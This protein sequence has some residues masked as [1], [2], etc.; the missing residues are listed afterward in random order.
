MSYE[1]DIYG[2]VIGTGGDDTSLQNEKMAGYPG[3]NMFD[4]QRDAAVL[5]QGE[6]EGKT[7]VNLGGTPV[8]N[9]APTGSQIANYVQG[10][11]GMP[12][13][14]SSRPNV[15][16]TRS[17][18]DA[19]AAAA[20]ERAAGHKVWG[21]QGTGM[22][23]E[24]WQRR[25]PITST[26][27]L[28]AAMGYTSPEEE[29]RLRKASVTNQRIMAIG[30]ALRHIGN[31]ANTVRY[32]P[33]QQFN[34]PVTDEIARYERGKALRDKANAALL[35]YQQQKERQDALQRRWENELEYKRQKEEAAAKAR[36]DKAKD[37][38]DKWKATLAYNKERDDKNLAFKK[39]QDKW[40]RED[41]TRRTDIMEAK[42][43]RGGGGGSRRVKSGTGRSA[44]GKM[45]YWIDVPG[46]GRVYYP[47][48]TMWKQGIDYY[49]NEGVRYTKTPGGKEEKVPY[50]QRGANLGRK[51]NNAATKGKTTAQGK[52]SG[53]GRSYSNTA[54]L[55]GKWG[56]KK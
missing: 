43:S 9:T 16:G 5:T 52:G 45:N 56:N 51:A 54:A 1:R 32:A 23:G 35:T 38:R 20:A 25:T 4:K 19:K 13:D 49:D 21:D 22:L 29:E 33:S 39:E 36:A 10:N 7:G 11:G 44:N 55:L 27:Q 28:A 40:K 26:E 50:T 24:Y 37:A 17:V 34:S 18:A 46:K 53:N 47:N 8:V 31:I 14:L 48:Q 15:L 2:N 12:Q 42:A 30:D 41:T 6:I 3:Y